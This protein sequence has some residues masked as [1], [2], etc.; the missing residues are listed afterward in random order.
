MLMIFALFIA[1]SLAENG[2]KCDIEIDEAHC[3]SCVKVEG[4]ADSVSCELQPEEVEGDIPKIVCTEFSKPANC[5]KSNL[6]K[7]YQCNEG[8]YL[9]GDEC[10]SCSDSV[11]NCGTCGKEGDNPVCYSCKAVDDVQLYLSAD[12]SECLDCSKSE[13]AEKCGR[14]P[15]GQYMKEDD[16]CE[17]CIENC[18]LC[19]GEG[20]CFQCK[21][22]YLLT[23]DEN[24]NDYCKKIENCER[25]KVDHCEVCKVGFRLSGGDCVAC[26]ENCVTCYS[27]S[28]I[29]G[30]CSVCEEGFVLGVDH[31]CHTASELN[32]T[33]NE[34]EGCLS[35]NTGYYF[36]E[37]KECQKCDDM[38]S[39]CVS[40]SKHC[41]TC[42]EGSFFKA[43]TSECM[44]KDEKCSSYDLTGCKTC[45][46]DN[47]KNERGWFVP[48]NEQSCKQCDE[49]CKSC[50]LRSDNCSICMDNY[51][52]SVVGNNHMKC[53]KMSEGC[54]K[55]SNG[56][57]SECKEGYNIG[58]FDCFKCDASC[59][60]CTQSDSCISCSDGYFMPRNYSDLG[61]PSLCIAYEAVNSNCNEKEGGMTDSYGCVKCNP[62]YYRIP[63]D[64]VCRECPNGCS[65]CHYD[66]TMNTTSDVVC[67]SCK[68][69]GDKY[70]ENGNCVECSTIDHCS[71]CNSV[72]CYK[73]GAFYEIDQ[74]DMTCKMS[75]TLLAMVIILVVVV[76]VSVIVIVGL[77]AYMVIQNKKEHSDSNEQV[78]DKSKSS[79]EL[80]SDDSN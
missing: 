71:E 24:G 69:D 76:V 72:G 54:V 26:P 64:Y 50:S 16:I 66:D 41:L 5:A 21:E 79:V 20:N 55:A 70:V 27:S 47:K 56:I 10:K 74:S 36:D 43:G 48:E 1:L 9:D 34:R 25:L 19:T 44:A 53:I 78:F 75:T 18:A 29:G 28:L 22:N 2:C 80:S 8:Y 37:N 12:G 62:G 60:T 59:K 65:T 73:C 39:T 42:P 30:S 35:C 46:N 33:G 32:C 14:C 31:L 17:N 6:D 68:G 67:D 63:S 77:I 52:L 45:T 7:C 11:S 13:N 4:A 3:V 40:D 58:D 15:N 51:V 49:G 38:C 23:K 57:C 61:L